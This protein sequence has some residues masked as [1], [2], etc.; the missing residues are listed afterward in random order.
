[1]GIG[2]HK[3]LNSK[4][5]PTVELEDGSMATTHVEAAD[6]WLRHFADEE[7]GVVVPVQEATGFMSLIP[8]LPEDLASDIPPGDLFLP[9]LADFQRACTTAKA[10]AASLDGIPGALLRKFGP[11]IA[12]HYY[13]VVMKSV[14]RL[15]EPL[16]WKGGNYWN[17][18]KRKAAPA[19][20]KHHRSVMISSQVG[21]KYRQLLREPL[22]QALP[23]EAGDSQYGGI[24]GRGVDLAALAL[25][26][27]QELALLQKT[28]ALFVMIDAISAFYRAIRELVLQ[29]GTS[30]ADLRRILHTAGLPEDAV[31]DLKLY[32]STHPTLLETAEYLIMCVRWLQTATILPGFGILGPHR[33]LLRYREQFQGNSWGTSSLIT[34][35]RHASKRP[36]R[37]CRS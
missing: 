6:R 17:I 8:P 3:R 21:K 35:C 18:W 31:E 27:F 32:I 37:A 13:P 28:S 12:S 15:E 11:T 25:R 4:P 23:N 5:L 22:V 30:D 33:L 36:K 26:C 1:M 7:V 2:S 20:C 16:Q 9:P 14:L 29:L 34:S 24:E 10:S 19:K